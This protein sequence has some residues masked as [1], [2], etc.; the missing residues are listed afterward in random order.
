MILK[1]LTILVPAAQTGPN[2]ISCI[3]GTYHIFTSANEYAK[4]SGKQ[5]VFHIQLAGVS[6]QSDFVNGLLSVTP[7]VHI[8]SI[9]KT[10]LVI[11]PAIK[12]EFSKPDKENLALVNWIRE[13]YKA[14][15]ELASM[16]TGAYLLASTGLL[17]NRGCSIHW[18]AVDNFRKLFPKVNM[19]AE[20]L[21]TDE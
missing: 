12:S 10:D 5:P 2:T 13:Q 4:A 1:Q 21:I 14:G 3:V 7:Q 6:E 8:S 18:N 20:K 9:R 17:D 16:C 19:K 15:A 11:I